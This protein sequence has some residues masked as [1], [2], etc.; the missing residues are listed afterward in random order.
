MLKRLTDQTP[1]L[2]AT[3]NDKILSTN[4]FK[5]KIFTFEEQS[6][7]EELCGFLEGFKAATVVLSS[8][9]KGTSSSILPAYAKF[10]KMLTPKDDDSPVMKKMKEL[11]SLECWGE[12]RVQ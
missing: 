5:S 2:H 7:T 12:N 3:A 4:D 6:L 9:S 10:E 1:A 8:E 11:G